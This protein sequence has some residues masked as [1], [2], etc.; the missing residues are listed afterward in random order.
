MP[1]RGLHGHTLGLVQRPLRLGKRAKV[2]SRAQT[3]KFH[4]VRVYHFQRHLK[5]LYL[6]QDVLFRASFRAPSTS[7]RHRASGSAH[8]AHDTVPN[9]IYEETGDFACLLVLLL[10]LG[11]AAPHNL[12]DVL[13]YGGIEKVFNLIVVSFREMPCDVCPSIPKHLVLLTDNQFFSKPP[14]FASLCCA[15]GGGTRCSAW[16]LVR[17]YLNRGHGLWHWLGLVEGHQRSL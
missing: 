7:V 10:I 13:P 12:T 1:L 8:I 6:L 17:L 5:A 14:R 3:L 15:F 4:E 9:N 2:F 11:Y 16:E